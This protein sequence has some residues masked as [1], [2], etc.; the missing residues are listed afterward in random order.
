MKKSIVL[1]LLVCVSSLAAPALAQDSPTDAACDLTALQTSIDTF[2][3]AAGKLK[4]ETDTV[5]VSNGLQELANEANSLRATCDGLSF[6][7]TK[8]L[9]IG[10]VTIP[11]GIYRAKATTD[12]AIIVELTILDGECEDRSSGETKGIFALTSGTA[13]DTAETIFNSKG[14]SALIEV[15]LVRADWQLAFERISTN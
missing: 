3:E 1:L 14:C 9:V 13:K 2:V 15:S 4:A 11:Q 6:S 7:G 5:K 10:P 12:E 8:Q